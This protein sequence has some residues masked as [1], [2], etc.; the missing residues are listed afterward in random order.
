M[1][2]TTR[3]L[4]QMERDPWEGRS[5]AS[6]RRQVGSDFP[7]IPQVKKKL[8]LHALKS[9]WDDIYRRELEAA[10]SRR[11]Y[12]QQ[13]GEQAG[14]AERMPTSRSSS[15]AS[16]RSSTCSDDASVDGEEWFQPECAKIAS[17]V[18]S[19]LRKQEDNPLQ[20]FIQSLH[21]LHINEQKRLFICEEERCMCRMVRGPPH[22]FLLPI[23]DVGC[24]GGQF[25]ARLRRC[26]F[27]RLAGIDYSAS[28]IRLAEL[29][30]IHQGALS[31]CHVCLRQADLR[32]L[33]PEAASSH[34]ATPP[35]CFCCRCGRTAEASCGSDKPERKVTEAESSCMTT[36]ACEPLAS[37]PPFPVVF[38]KGTFD[39]FWLMHTPEEYVECMHRLMPR[40]AILFLTS[41]NC[42]VE[43]VDRIFCATA[44][45]QRRPS[46]AAG[47]VRVNNDVRASESLQKSSAGALP[48][49]KVSGGTTSRS[50]G[51]DTTAIGHCRFS[52]NPR[53]PFER[54]ALL[55]HRTFK[56][57]G[58]VGQV[59]TSVLLRRL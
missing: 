19:T 17:W 35:S 29:N 51:G 7:E 10:T 42:T 48:S 41:C 47:D 15:R 37:L 52:E 5:S 2:S 45:E 31:N 9:T 11:S 56:F 3:R 40:Y 43:E 13:R 59:V 23:L 33:Q 44:D 16:R 1:S 54:I 21:A 6:H 20:L 49:S 58:V 12:A 46:I 27:A 14:P 39:V 36:C 8:S 32:S 57:G 53:P 18:C 30:L 26:G 22:C 34:D 4:L 38:D 25:L 55:P 28:A 50:L 24:G